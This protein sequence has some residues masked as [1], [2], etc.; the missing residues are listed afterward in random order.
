MARYSLSLSAQE[1]L[2]GI[3]DYYLEHS[4]SRAAR[5]ILVEFVQAFRRLAATRGVGHKREDLAEDR[6]VRF[7]PL[8]DYLIVY[9]STTDQVQIVTVVHGMRD[10]ANLLRGRPL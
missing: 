10:V 7:W 2:V 9:R 8:R 5:Q 4:G 6:P 3:R 1:D